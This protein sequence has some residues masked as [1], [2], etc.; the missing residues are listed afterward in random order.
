MKKNI[1]VII[2]FVLLIAIILSGCLTN[3]NSQE[4]PIL[5]MDNAT[6]NLSNG[7]IVADYNG[8]AYYFKQK[9]GIVERSESQEKVIYPLESNLE[10]AKISGLNIL[11]DQ[12]YFFLKQNANIMDKSDNGIYRMNLDG[13]DA[14]KIFEPKSTI[15][16]LYV[17]GDSIYFWVMEDQ[18]IHKISNDGS[19][20]KKLT[21]TGKTNAFS[22]ENGKIYYSFYDSEQEDGNGIYQMDLNGKNKKFV[23]DHQ[24]RIDSMFCDENNLYYLFMYKP[25]EHYIEKD[26][27][28]YYLEDGSSRKFS[29]HLI[30]AAVSDGTIY[31]GDLSDGI[32]TA[33]LYCGEDIS[34]QKDEVLMEWEAKDF[35]L[36]NKDAFPYM[37]MQW[38]GIAQNEV[39]CIFP[40][41]DDYVLKIVPESIADSKPTTVSTPKTGPSEEEIRSKYIQNI[42]G[43]WHAV[44]GNPDEV[45]TINQ[46]EEEMGF[47]Q[48]GASGMTYKY[49]IASVDGN[50]GVL[51]LYEVLDH[52]L[53]REAQKAVYSECSETI[54]IKV[55]ENGHLSIKDIECAAGR[56]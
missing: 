17:I 4:Y 37:K 50:S 44:N 5:Q 11:E 55:L 2:M 33:R 51:E 31:R 9:V 18:N 22:Y 20:E 3:E 45:F 42:Q 10:Y 54:T 26:M 40:G 1:I 8:R 32:V 35:N 16:N 47:G 15:S 41:E 56:E 29:N 48:T 23:Q 7:G 21:D 52:Q 30:G 13:S 49:R 43:I 34:N 38:I 12:V 19:N 39:Y 46:P 28:I 25:E 53:S 6:S 27:V 14:Q 24:S 36:E